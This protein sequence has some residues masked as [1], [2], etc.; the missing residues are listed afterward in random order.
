MDL[1]QPH[2]AG[3]F[4]CNYDEIVPEMYH[5]LLI[6]KKPTTYLCFFFSLSRSEPGGQSFINLFIYNFT[7][8]QMRKA[9]LF[10]A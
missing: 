10:R 9:R 2:K 8:E 4:L 7:S 5:A 1:I 3:L 6:F